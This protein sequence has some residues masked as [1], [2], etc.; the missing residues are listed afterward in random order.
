MR[1]DSYTTYD[2][3]LG[4]DRVEGV[5]LVREKGG[6]ASRLK[7]GS[8]RDHR[9]KERQAGGLLVEYDSKPGDQGGPL[10]SA[11]ASLHRESLRLNSTYPLYLYR[12]GT[13]TGPTGLDRGRLGQG[14]CQPLGAVI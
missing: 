2:R 7:E 8:E 12:H 5:L 14:S 3:H 1:K 11:H 10:L 13:H 4:D 9:G 6:E